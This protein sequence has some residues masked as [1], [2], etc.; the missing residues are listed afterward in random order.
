MATRSKMKPPIPT[1]TPPKR[2]L[3]KDALGFQ[4]GESHTEGRKANDPSA[5]GYPAGAGAVA[6]CPA[7]AVS[8]A[9]TGASAAAGGGAGTGGAAAWISES[10]I[11]K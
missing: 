4:D 7:V 10:T 11:D 2:V 1:L 3:P 6:S 8:G 5:H 9:A